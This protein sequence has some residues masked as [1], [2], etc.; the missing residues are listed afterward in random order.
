MSDADHAVFVLNRAL[1]Q[2]GDVLAAVRRDQLGDPTPC[3]DWDVAHLVG[4]VVASPRNF[5][6]MMQ[7]G[8]PDWSAGPEPVTGG[9][10]AQFRSAADDLIHHWH[11]LGDTAD[12]GQVDWQTAEMAVHTWDVARATGQATAGFDPEVAE[13]GLGFMSQ[14][15]TAENRGDAFGPEREAPEG[16]GP[17]ER[18]AAFAGRSLA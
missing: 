13:R 1:D 4:H 11:Q 12:P 9:W 16:A 18:L 15:L 5:L 8:Q 7:G 3:H 17:Y 10:T 6:T 2:L 14:G